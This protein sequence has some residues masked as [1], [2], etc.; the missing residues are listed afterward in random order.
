MARKQQAATDIFGTEIKPG[1]I[2]LFSS[3]AAKLDVAVVKEVKYRADGLLMGYQVVVPY[4]DRDG[5]PAEHS[6]HVRAGRELVCL[7]ASRMPALASA[8]ACWTSEFGHRMVY[9]SNRLSGADE[10]PADQHA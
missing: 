6:K 1:S 10:T 4:K 8:Q 2:V 9:L 3:A 5:K 7:P